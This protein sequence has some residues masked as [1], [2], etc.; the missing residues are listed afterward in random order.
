MATPHPADTT[1]WC[2][3]CEAPSEIVD[4]FEDQVGYEEQARTVWVIALNCGHSISSRGT[5]DDQQAG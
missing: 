5:L 1:D 3:T 4:Q 2:P